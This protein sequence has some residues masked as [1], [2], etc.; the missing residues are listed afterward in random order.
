MSSLFDRDQRQGN[1][2]DLVNGF[3]YIDIGERL[4]YLLAGQ[5]VPRR[6]LFQNL[7]RQ[8]YAAQRLDQLMSQSSP[9]P[10]LYHFT[11]I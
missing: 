8:K 9:S 5:G 3:I 4:F 6:E 2:G 10:L 7:L 1:K 11:Q